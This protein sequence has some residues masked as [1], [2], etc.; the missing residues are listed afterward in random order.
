M[1]YIKTPLRWPGGKSKALKTLIPHVPRYET[2][3]EAFLG[4][5]SMFLRLAQLHPD[6]NYWINDLDT[7]TFSIWN[8]LYNRPDDMINY[9]MEQKNANCLDSQKIQPSSINFLPDQKMGTLNLQ[10]HTSNSVTS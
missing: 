6:K 2:F 5:G 9:I 1:T 3:I 8:I 4:G 10:Y 7:C